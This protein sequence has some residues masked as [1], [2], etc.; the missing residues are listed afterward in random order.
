MA[1]SDKVASVYA[2]ALLGLAVEAKE[3]EAT[4]EELLALNAA[5]TA[6]KNV[7]GFF[8]SPLIR[9]KVKMRVVDAQLKSQLGTLLYNFTGVVTG[10]GRLGSLPEIVSAYSGLLDKHLKRRRVDV[11]TA[12]PLDGSQ[13]DALKAAIE[14]YTGQSVIMSVSEDAELLGGMKI[15]SGDLLIDSSKKSQLAGLRQSLMQRK[16][17]GEEYYEN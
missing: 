11:Q 2:E 4:E 6:D 1:I 10:R 9:S 5:L 17:L 12:V 16:I 14:K 13:V 8:R 15:R 7:W 3:A